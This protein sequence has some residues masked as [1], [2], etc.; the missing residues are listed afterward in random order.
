MLEDRITTIA[1]DSSSKE[2]EIQED[3]YGDRRHSGLASY[4]PGRKEV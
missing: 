1:S 4:N 2:G 3:L